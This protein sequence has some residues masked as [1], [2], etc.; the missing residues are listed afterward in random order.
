MA[1]SSSTIAMRRAMRRLYPKPFC[2]FSAIFRRRIAMGMARRVRFP[3]VQWSHHTRRCAMQK[4]SPLPALHVVE[5]LAQVALAAA[6]GLFVSLVLAG[7]VLLL[8]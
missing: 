7:V 4:P 6:T 5:M 1:A 2:H 8:A 3:A